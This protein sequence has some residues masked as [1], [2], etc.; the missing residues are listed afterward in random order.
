MSD[1]LDGVMRPTNRHYVSV[2][3]KVQAQS[4]ACSCPSDTPN[5]M[6]AGLTGIRLTRNAEFGAGGASVRP[7]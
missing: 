7:D 4:I 2:E 3:D 1:K 5:G 6:I